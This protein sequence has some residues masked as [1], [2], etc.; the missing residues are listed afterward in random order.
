MP[1]RKKRKHKVSKIDAQTARDVRRL[2]GL[3]PRA[4]LLIVQTEND[5]RYRNGGGG[6][7]EEGPMTDTPRS[8]LL[9]LQTEEG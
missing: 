3:G 1:L 4:H 9:K 7:Y 5:S 2:L 6:R 8:H